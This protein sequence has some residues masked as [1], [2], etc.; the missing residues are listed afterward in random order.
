M[1][2]LTTFL[3]LLLLVGCA[4]R[5]QVHIFSLGMDTREIEHLSSLLAEEGFDVRPN[6]LPVPGGFFRHAVIFPAITQNFSMV[7]Q[8]KSAMG[9]AG[10]SNAQMILET[11][12]NHY[13]STNNIGVYLINPD[14]KGSAASLIQHPLALGGADATPL[15]F[16]YFSECP[17]G[18]EAQSELNLYPSGVAILEEFI[19]HDED[20]REISV[21]H[22]GEWKSDSSSVEIDI[23]GSGE[24][25]FSIEEH[26]G[27]NWF[28]PYKGLTL[29]NQLNTMD[30]EQCD[31]THL[32]HEDSNF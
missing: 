20:N 9:K 5:T 25:R 32:E 1:L 27:S 3:S 31:Y 17:E 7:E 26:I 19:W 24:L 29:K 10:Y 2:R 15:T 11:E 6:S 23:F 22:D 8:V 16:N 28:G 30:I 18:S 14:F 13:Y 21:M 12:A 4:S